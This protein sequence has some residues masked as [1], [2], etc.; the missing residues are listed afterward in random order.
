MAP[1]L[2]VGC[3]ELVEFRTDITRLQSDFQANAQALSQLSARMD[4]LERRQADA[5][6]AAR[7]T[8]QD[9]A[10]AIEGPLSKAPMTK[11]RQLSPKS[12]KS[13]P[14]D[15]ERPE[16]R[17]RQHSAMGQ[18]ASARGKNSHQEPKQLSLGMNQD[19]VRRIWGQPINIEP[20]GPYLF[21]HYAPMSKQ[22]Y[23]ILDKM[24]GEVLGWR[25]L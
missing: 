12:G 14:K 13:A 15:T 17:A 16:S 10:R 8:Q 20:V 23:I 3:A 11:D 18:E 25:G 1:F 4:D 6:S 24:S 2:L 22:Q 5:E 7:Q 19:D 9:L 21:W